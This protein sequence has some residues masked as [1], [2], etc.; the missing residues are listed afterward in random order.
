[1]IFFFYGEDSFRSTEKLTQI[2]NKFQKEIDHK[3][4]NISSLDGESLTLEEFYSAVKQTGF[5]TEKRLIIIRNF[6]K[7]KKRKDFEK[8]IIEFLKSQKD[9]KEENFIIFWEDGVPRKNDTLIKVLLGFKYVSEL[10]KLNNLQLQQWITEKIRTENGTIEP[11]AVKTLVTYLG[12]DL[13][14]QNNEIDK[15]LAYKKN[16]LI[17]ASDVKMLIRS[18][19]DENIFNLT[20]AVGANNKKLA[21]QLINDQLSS[22]TNHLYL[23]TMIIRQFRIL[24]E[25]KS[26]SQEFDSYP[27]VAAQ[28]TLHPFVLRKTWPLLSI[29]TWQQ[30]KRIYTSLVDL[31]KNFKST[32]I[33]PLLLF[34]KFIAEL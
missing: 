18:K 23:L 4:Y 6:F 30:L 5:L 1:M 2:K 31:E 8:E 29:F 12:N 25:L 7:N 22:G 19:L 34:D 28:S 14:Q 24:L 10:K 11:E 16:Q 9:T 27:K 20:D 3:G 21:L 26:L 33:N 15:L 32:S 13:W 17:T